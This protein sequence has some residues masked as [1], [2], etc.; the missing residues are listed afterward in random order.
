MEIAPQEKEAIGKMGFGE[1]RHGC[2][3]ATFAY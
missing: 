1:I 2:V 3:R